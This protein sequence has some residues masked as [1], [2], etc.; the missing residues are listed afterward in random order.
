MN[1]QI[2]LFKT[3]IGI[4]GLSIL[5][6]GGYFIYG[7]FFQREVDSMARNAPIESTIISINKRQPMPVAVGLAAGIAYDSDNDL[8]FI[9]TDQPQTLRNIPEAQVHVLNSDLDTVEATTL[10]TTDG[11]L[12]GIAYIGNS[13][14]VAI[15]EIGTL[16]YLQYD[17]AGGLVE[18]RRVTALDDTATHKLGSL[19]A[20]PVGEHL[21]SAE[22]EGT[23]TI[24]QFDYAGNL[25]N[26]FELTIPDSFASSRAYSL[27]TDYT[28]AGMTYADGFLYIFSEAYSTIFKFDLASQQVTEVI[29]VESLPEVAGITAKG[30][31][32]VFVGDFESYLP[33]PVFHIASR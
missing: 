24:Y 13:T 27:D 6:G 11:D 22:K 2:S 30:G 5:L 18:Q 8:F 7:S 14:A 29:G 20:D 3:I 15:S 23:K 10:L 28:I 1:K 9:S 31:E 4:I 16:I 32:L 19:A 17:G 21:Y 33:T 25:L 26:S 12:E